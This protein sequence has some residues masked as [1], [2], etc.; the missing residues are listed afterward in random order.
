MKNLEDLAKFPSENPN[1]VLRVT[2]NK[3]LYVNK[4]GGV[5]FSLKEGDKIP[6]LFQSKLIEA[7]NKNILQTL[8]VEINNNDYILDIIP[9][10][11]EGYVNI[12]GKEITTRKRADRTILEERNKAQSYLDLAGVM[13]IALDKNGNISLINKKGCE[14]LGYLEEELIGKQWFKT[15]IPPRLCDPVFKDFKRLLRGELEPIEFYENPILTKNGEERIIAWHNS[16]L[17][18]KEENIIGT[19]TSGEDI[20]ER[21]R[22][23]LKLEESERKY[24]L[25]F[26]NAN[27]AISILDLEGNFYEVNNL[28]LTRLGYTR[29]EILKSN[30][31]DIS[32]PEYAD[33]VSDRMV[34]IKEKG[35]KVFES[36]HKAKDGSIIS[37]EISS[38]SILYEK[39]P[40]ILNIVRDITERRKAEEA[41]RESEQRL[42]DAQALGKI[43][44]WEFDVDKQNLLWSD[45]VFNLYKRDRTRGIPTLEDEAAYYSP[46]EAK[47]LR[48][49]GQ[50]AIEYGQEFEYDLE[51]NLPDGSI[52]QLSAFMRP[53]KNKSGRVTKLFGTVQDI[54][55]RKIAEE[56][57]K[58]SQK[59]YKLLSEEFELIL[60]HII[61]PVF[62]KDTKNSF[63]WVNKYIADAYK[64]K[65]EDLIGKSLFEL[66]P[67]EVAQTY[68]DDDLDVINSGKSKLNIVET[69]DTVDGLKWLLTSKI[70]F[71]DENGDI[72]GIIGT[73]V[74]ITER[75]IAEIELQKSEA[76]YREAYN[77]AEFYKDIFTHDISNILQNI[78]NGIQ[79]NEMYFN[80]PEKSDKVKR[81]IDIIKRQ[82]KRGATL[83][84]N[85]RKLSRISE[86]ETLL[87]NV[88]Y[89]DILKKSINYINNTFQNKNIKIELQHF[90]RNFKIL[91]NELLSDVFE[92]I[93]TNSI[94]YND[95]EEI[96]IE[97]KVN[98]ELRHGINYI[99]MQIIDNG[100]G[101]TDERKH[102]IFTRGY[103]EETSVHGMGLGLSLVKKIIES[104]NGEIW[105]EDRVKG[106]YT[107]GCDCSV[108]IPEV[109][110]NG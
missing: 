39:K 62:Y 65:R 18:D 3:V 68:W 97:V 79:L 82:V 25:I 78:S 93:L 98:R 70:P 23:E 101:I 61:G 87:F 36:A 104:Y 83:V 96:Y 55:A 109:L 47:R 107:K 110:N 75:K 31:R 13:I 81:N 12:Y 41:L 92:N 105:M 19:L 51:A 27:D 21:R 29:E 54:T 84:S 35:F 91:A 20:T 10:K 14:V 100:I 80:K 73:S 64:M 9:I 50:R 89:I 33:L 42:K 103:S 57:L 85:V 66:S 32:V 43:G 6:E 30:I 106:D 11:G 53:I 108:L 71:I 60:D 17:Y 38:K 45:Q 16:L 99:K 90:E 59:K 52:I 48:E 76:T 8:E 22:T 56:N 67:E 102:Q 94:N 37:V 95:S 44:D 86:S 77:R 63:I 26:E 2:K 46:K 7:L 49:Y 88:N 34:D 40:A 74:D 5:L 72:K 15:L 69:W 28:Y 4:P 1:P 58:K 24:R